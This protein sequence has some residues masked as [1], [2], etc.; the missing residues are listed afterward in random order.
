MTEE[1]FIQQ[2]FKRLGVKNAPVPD[3]CP[4]CKGEL[5]EA[6]G[7]AGETVLYCPAGC[8]ICW[9]DSEQAI[10]NVI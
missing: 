10:R 4:K 8:G 5:H 9:E 7:Y 1:Q 6:D 2:E 3:V